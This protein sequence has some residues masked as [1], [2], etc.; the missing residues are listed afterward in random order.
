[1]TNAQN[2]HRKNASIELPA[3]VFLGAIQLAESIP[4]DRDS[5]FWKPEF[6]RRGIFE[7]HPALQLLCGWFEEHRVDAKAMNCG[8]AMPWVRI[9]DNG[10]YCCGYHDTPS[11]RMALFE[12]GAPATALLG[13]STIVTF[14]ASH[15]HAVYTDEMGL[16][17]FLADGQSLGQ[18][19][20]P[21]ELFES[22]EYD[23]AWYSLEALASFRR[24]F[25]AAFE[26]IKSLAALKIN[27]ESDGY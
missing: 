23:E 27:G 22:G 6:L 16:E 3:S 21:K 20:I 5:D 2:Q 12:A 4:F 18:V 8:Y 7:S 10:K 15:E 13:E 25:P 1:M 14:C 9:L 11:E 17:N 26:E 19:G 24:R